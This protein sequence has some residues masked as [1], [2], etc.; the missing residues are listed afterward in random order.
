MAVDPGA[1]VEQPGGRVFALVDVALAGPRRMREGP[2]SGENWCQI[3][4]FARSN[5]L[6]L[7]KLPCS[8]HDDHAQSRC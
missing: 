1:D 5:V 6:F 8:C 4:M 7:P 3:A 2:S